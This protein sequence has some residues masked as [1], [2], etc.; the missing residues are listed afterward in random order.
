MPSVMPPEEQ[1]PLLA[2]DPLTIT[3]Q[4]ASDARVILAAGYAL[5]LQVAHPTV[6]AGV[7]EHSQFLLDPWGG[8]YGRSTTRAQSSTEARGRP[9]RWGGGCARSTRRSRARDPT[10]GAIT[11]SS[12]WR[13]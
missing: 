1:W 11:R 9:V 6:G 10:G 4:C 12:R 3:W 8:C 13:T 7:S 5:L 2:P